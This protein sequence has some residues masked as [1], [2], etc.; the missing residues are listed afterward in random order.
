MTT[1]PLMPGWPPESPVPPMPPQP[2]A[3]P[4][5]PATLPG[6]SE[7]VPAAED[8]LSQRLFDNRI[9]LVRSN[10][11]RDAATRLTAQLLALDATSLRP[12][13][14]QFD[15][16]SADLT[17]ALLLADT[18]ELMRATTHGLVIGGVGGASLAILA[19][20][21]RRSAYRH[22]RL[23]LSQPRSDAAL[24]QGG[25][26]PDA[27]RR[28]AELVAD[29]VERL[30][31]VSHKSTDE[32]AADLRSRRYRTATEAVEYGLIHEVA[33]AAEPTD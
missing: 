17:A 20:T 2:A 23:R 22:A 13:R 33:G 11:D 10:V 21:N 5:R 32:I 24:R 8:W 14:L 19:A 6:W 4:S 29:F 9:V 3:P 30:A 18:L 31:Q 15:T 12:V 26:E 28:H 27:A 1:T 25:D 7:R 16:R